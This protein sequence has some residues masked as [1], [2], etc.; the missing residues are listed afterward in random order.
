MNMQ[1]SRFN[2]LTLLTLLT[3]WACGCSIPR[4]LKGGK[5]FT[6]GTPSGRIDQTLV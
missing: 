5:A 3:I 4:P 6:T 2:I 1:P